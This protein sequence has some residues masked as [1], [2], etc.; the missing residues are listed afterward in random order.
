MPQRAQ[1]IAKAKQL[2]QSAGMSSVNVTLTTEQFLEIPQYA[3]YVKQMAAPAGFNITLDVVED[4]AWGEQVR[5]NN[6][7]E[8]AT[9][10]SGIQA[11]WSSRR[12]GRMTSSAAIMMFLLR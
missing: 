3:Q 12:I 8:M 4:V 2:L 7:F 11:S 9:R 5:I 10:Q 1:D 6:D